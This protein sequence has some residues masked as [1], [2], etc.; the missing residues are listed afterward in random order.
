MPLLYG[1]SGGVSTPSV[2]VLLDVLRSARPNET[3]RRPDRF[4]SLCYSVALLVSRSFAMPRPS[5]HTLRNKC[6]YTSRMVGYKGGVGEW[7]LGERQRGC[8]GSACWANCERLDGRNGLFWRCCVSLILFRQLEWFPS[9]QV[10]IE[11]DED[12]TPCKVA[13]APLTSRS[14]LL[15]PTT[16]L[17]VYDTPGLYPARPHEH[18]SQH[19]IAL[20]A[21]SLPDL[22]VNLRLRRPPSPHCKYG[23]YINPQWYQAQRRYPTPPTCLGSPSS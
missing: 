19:T 10:S 22:S 11:H 15:S 4:W 21:T 17:L 7:W 1:H 18:D 12:R 23:P 3:S 2:S 16:I 8:W 6:L 20:V 14:P 5:S 9:H 13:L